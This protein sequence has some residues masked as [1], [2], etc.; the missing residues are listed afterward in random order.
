LQGQLA[1]PAD[2]ETMDYPVLLALKVKLELL[3]FLEDRAKMDALVH[4]EI[5]DQP[6]RQVTS[7][8]FLRGKK[9]L[10]KMIF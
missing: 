7:H 2:P 8:N 1:Q 3:D 4:Q 9:T 6:V 10:I 5:Q